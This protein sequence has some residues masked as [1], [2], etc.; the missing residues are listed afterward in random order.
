MDS[1]AVTAEV[2][3]VVKPGTPL[4]LLAAARPPKQHAARTGCGGWA[5]QLQ[6]W[7]SW[8]DFGRGAILKCFDVFFNLKAA[9]WCSVSNADFYSDCRY[10][11]NEAGFVC[12]ATGSQ[13]WTFSSFLWLWEL[14]ETTCIFGPSRHWCRGRK[15][16]RWSLVF[17]SW[18]GKPSRRQNEAL[19]R[20]WGIAKS[21]SQRLF[22]LEAEELDGFQVATC[23]RLG[24]L[25]MLD[26]WQPWSRSVGVIYRKSTLLFE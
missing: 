9:R 24:H 26:T 19:Q 13:G 12:P 2:R 16:P 18:C 25:V 5:F 1:S 4:Q 20:I 22:W 8:A 14:Q 17:W 21:K 3:F 7:L 6:R 15:K 23:S 11:I 10:G